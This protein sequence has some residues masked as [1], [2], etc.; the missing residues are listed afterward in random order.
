MTKDSI[1]LINENVLPESNV[2]LYNAELDLSMMACFSSLDRTE[3]QFRE[4]LDSV[5]F[6]L[7]KVWRPSVVVPG[8]GTLFEAVRK[9]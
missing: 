2:S 8:S 1:L 6:E 3:A 4:L 9:Q 7:V 5:G